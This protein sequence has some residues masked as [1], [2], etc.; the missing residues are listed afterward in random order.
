[1]SEER[2]SSDQQAGEPEARKWQPTGLP[3]ADE[4]A[5]VRATQGQLEAVAMR[6]REEL[7]ASLRRTGTAAR[8]SLKDDVLYVRV[9][10]SL[11]PA[12]HN[13]MRRAA[14]R[15]FFQHYIEELAEQIHP[16]F[17]RHVENI[18]PCS[19]TYIRVKVDCDDDCITFTFGLRPR[20]TWKERLVAQQES[21]A[22]HA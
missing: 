3:W 1:M 22:P 20:L 13:L 14:G 17:Q 2:Y 5:Q 9:E 15:D 7:D 11:A 8:A 12:E 4:G 18:L 19:V 6:C 10:H 21:Q 16:A